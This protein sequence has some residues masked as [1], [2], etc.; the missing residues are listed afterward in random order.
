MV[1]ADAALGREFEKML[2][3]DNRNAS[4]LG[5]TPLPLDDI[6]HNTLR[7]RGIYVT[8]AIL[9]MVIHTVIGEAMRDSATGLC[10]QQRTAA[11]KTVFALPNGDRAAYLLPHF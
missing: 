10:A 4:A 2:D 9:G 5:E 7:L 3:L 1:A 8:T 6:G 11:S